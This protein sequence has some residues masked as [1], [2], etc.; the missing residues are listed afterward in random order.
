MQILDPGTMPGNLEGPFTSWYPDGK[1]RA[2]GGYRSEG[3]SSVPDGLWVFWKPDG[4]R[5][6]AGHYQRGTPV[7]CFS[8]W[9][10]SGVEHIGIATAGIV[11]EQPCAAP[12][13]AELAI[14]EG[15]VPTPEPSAPWGDASVA[16]FVGPNGIGATA[17]SQDVAHG[18]TLAFSASAR[19][20]LGRLRLGPFAGVRLGD[21]AG[22]GAYVAGAGVAW[23]LPRFHPRIDSEI[24]A[25]IGV[26]RILVNP[27]RVG[28]IANQPLVFWSTLPAIQATF[29]IALTPAIAA[30]AALR[31]E[32][33]PAFGVAGTS[34]YCSFTACDAPVTETW[35]VGGFA[36]G[37]TLG[38]RLLL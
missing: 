33:V 22:D 4:T 20:Y 9:D 38:L 24:G 21:D 17:P 8:V 35:Q 29:A 26:A 6:L 28:K 32:G 18:M 30:T 19:K 12:S 31:V 36:Y 27:E 16:G 11:H 34:T 2:H 37:A 13:E 23:E 25:E 5:A 14:V 1:L 10:A 15:R 7:G 3:A